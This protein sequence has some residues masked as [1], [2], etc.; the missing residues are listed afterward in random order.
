MIALRNA[1]EPSDM[2]NNFLLWKYSYTNSGT[3]R[4]N[5]ISFAKYQVQC[6]QLSADFHGIMLL[7]KRKCQIQQLLHSDIVSYIKNI[8]PS[9]PNKFKNFQKKSRVKAQSGNSLMYLL[10][11]IFKIL[12]MFPSLSFILF[13]KKKQERNAVSQKNISTASSAEITKV[14]RAL[15]IHSCIMFKFQRGPFSIQ[16]YVL[17]NMITTNVIT[18]IPLSASNSLNS[19]GALFLNSKLKFSEIDK[20]YMNLY[21]HV[22]SCFGFLCL[23]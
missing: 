6:M 4:K 8:G 1:T 3:N 19:D 9:P 21:P 10:M 20:H 7:M 16:K 17:P 14:K 22:T 23:Y 12:P 13:N 15:S 5:C 2:Q 11:Y 18:L